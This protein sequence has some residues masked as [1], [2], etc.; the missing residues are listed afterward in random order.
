MP[1]DGKKSVGLQTT[2]F[3][4]Q[5]C[6]FAKKGGKTRIVATER[7]SDEPEFLWS[8]FLEQRESSSS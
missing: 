6:S 2:A 5:S 8:T 7:R 4:H 1:I 3:S